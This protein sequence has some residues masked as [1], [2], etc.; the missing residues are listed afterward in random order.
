MFIFHNHDCRLEHNPSKEERENLSLDCAK[1]RRASVLKQAT[2]RHIPLLQNI[3]NRGME[4][5]K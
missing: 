1:S 3:Y 4:S 5:L 2:L